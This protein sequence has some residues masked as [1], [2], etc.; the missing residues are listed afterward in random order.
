M[1]YSPE[2]IA[3]VASWAHWLTGGLVLL[4]AVIA[5]AALITESSKLNKIWPVIIIVAGL[6][7]LIDL[8]IFLEVP[9]SHKQTHFVFALML[10][11]I[12]LLQWVGAMARSSLALLSLQLANAALL[13]VGMLLVFHASNDAASDYVTMFHQRLGVLLVLAALFK[14]IADNLHG[15]AWHIIW[16]TLI[17]TAGLMLVSYEEP[18]QSAEVRSL[19]PAMH[20]H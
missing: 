10:L 8:I 16:L 17:V 12:G 1:D 20:H 2:Y 13:I 4:G 9:D 19:V 18:G 6:V 15:K 11:A 5:F 7:L 3:A 14:I